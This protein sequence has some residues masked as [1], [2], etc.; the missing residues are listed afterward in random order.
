MGFASLDEIC[1]YIRRKRLKNRGQ[2]RGCIKRKEKKVVKKAEK[3]KRLWQVYQDEIVELWERG[4]AVGTI[5]KKLGVS[6]KTVVTALKKKGIL[7]EPRGR[8]YQ[9]HRGTLE[10]LSEYVLNPSFREL[11]EKYGSVQ[12]YRVTEFFRHTDF[13]R[14]RFLKQSCRIEVSR[15]IKRFLK[16]HPDKEFFTLDELKPLVDEVRHLKKMWKGKVKELAPEI[17]KLYLSGHTVKEIAR[18][19]NISEHSVMDVV[20]KKRYLPRELVYQKGGD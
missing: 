14:P 8:M 4:Y 6:E 11:K 3:G 2:K 16:E 13:P 19:L 18:R 1:D 20:Y 9:V 7:P 15:A 12:A 17:W 5:A 10:V